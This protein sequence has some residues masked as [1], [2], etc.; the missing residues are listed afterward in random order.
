MSGP[1]VQWGVLLGKFRK[2][3]CKGHTE[4]KDLKIIIWVSQNITN[5]PEIN[6]K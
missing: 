3:E 4:S 5:I 1:F 6:V 2:M